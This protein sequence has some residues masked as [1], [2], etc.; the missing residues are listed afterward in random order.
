MSVH[1]CEEYSI[2]MIDGVL[3]S[4]HVTCCLVLIEKQ[5]PI[6]EKSCEKLAISFYQ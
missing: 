1:V 4:F 2:L 5:E 6:E 3:C